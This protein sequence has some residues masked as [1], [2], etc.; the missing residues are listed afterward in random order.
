ML[1]LPSIRRL[2]A[3]AYPASFRGVRDA[4]LRAGGAASGTPADLSSPRDSAKRL[5][6]R[7]SHRRERTVRVLGYAVRLYTRVSP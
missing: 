7:E 1:F 4:A 2:V 3:E 6:L 5:L